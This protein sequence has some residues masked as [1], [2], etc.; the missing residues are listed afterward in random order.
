[1]VSIVS[2]NGI[3]MAYALDGPPN[4]PVVMFSATMMCHY[5]I[6]DK[7]VEKLA[8]DYRV[9]RY[10]TRGHGG[11]DATTGA[12][13]LNL[14]ADDVASLLEALDIES[15]HFVGLSLGGFI[16]QVLTCR[17]PSIIESLVLCDTASQMPPKSMW[18]ERI[19]LVHREGVKSFPELMVQRWFTETYRDANPHEM[20]PIKKMIAEMSIDGMIGC[21]HAVK[22][23]NNESL[24]KDISVP[25]LIIVGEHDVSTPVSVAET[26]HKY[27][28][29]SELCIIKNAAHVSNFEQ[30]EQFNSAL[31]K[32][33]SNK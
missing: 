10:D 3:D 15:V 19:E 11:S 5:T 29:N 30:P 25:T 32:F 24:L 31:L 4:A 26:M 14:L 23:M 33:F 16:G 28:S 12:Y 21:C 27:I 13:T 17:H 8:T 2:A 18:D 20:E 1:M 9:L 7:Q 22:N 6:W